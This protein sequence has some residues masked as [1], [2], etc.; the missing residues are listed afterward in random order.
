MLDLVRLPRS[1]SM[2]SFLKRLKPGHGMCMFANFGRNLF[3]AR[4]RQG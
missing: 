2:I 3:P 1:L 4:L